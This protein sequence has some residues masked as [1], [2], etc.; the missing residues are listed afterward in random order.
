MARIAIE[1]TR[2]VTASPA[3]V[4]DRCYADAGAWP[5]WNP[6]LASAELQGP[7]AA[8]S[9]ARVRFRTGLRLQFRLIEVEAGRVFTDEARL[10]GARLGHRHLLDPHED[11]TLLRN[12]IYFEGPLAWLWSRAMS[13]R[14]VAALEEGQRRIAE[15]VADR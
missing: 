10:P 9:R 4:W 8:G 13:G 3:A 6:E 2:P 12:T 5:E 14:A 7:F 1:R 11:G 15:L